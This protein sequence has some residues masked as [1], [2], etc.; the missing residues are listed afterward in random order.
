MR[1]ITRLALAAGLAALFIGVLGAT[2]HVPEAKAET[3]GV[4][5]KN[6]AF[7]PATVNAK[8]GEA[9]RWI[10]DEDAV[11]HTVTSEAFGTFNSPT[12]RPGAS[13][14]QQFDTAGAYQYFCIVHP[15]M[16]GVVLVGDATGAPSTPWA[17]LPSA[18]ISLRLSGA[19]E[20]PAVTTPAT[21]TFIATP[22][23]NSL[24]YQMQLSS[25]G[26]LVSHIHSGAV[27]V[28]GP[29]VAFLYGPATGKNLIEASGTLTVTN[30]VGPMAGNWKAF[31]DALTAG[32]LYV[33]AHSA[34]YPGGEI[35]A[36][37]P[38]ATPPRPPAT[39]SGTVSPTG[40]DNRMLFGLLAAGA[41]V[42]GGGATYAQKRR[43]R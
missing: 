14:T 18:P 33:N 9:V 36:Q 20:V 17:V 41:L 34:A 38:S 11:P 40:S 24:A 16:R 2:H 8:V 39:G 12:M 10:N 13:F 31:S 6:F 3:R 23:A 28:N 5:I 27:G 37:I 19:N 21:G 35:R 4:S 43:S 1:S 15:R 25:N 32:T 7:A 30:L 42:I 26:V 22:G 29:V